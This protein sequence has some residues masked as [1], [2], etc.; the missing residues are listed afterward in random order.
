M[1]LVLAML[2][3]TVLLIL[4]SNCS[5]ELGVK[6]EH[7]QPRRRRPLQHVEGVLTVRSEGEAAHVAEQPAQ[8]IPVAA[9]A[10]PETKKEQ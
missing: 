9:G 10:V 3:E 2:L 7:L 1:G 6:Y 5:P 4:R 8:D